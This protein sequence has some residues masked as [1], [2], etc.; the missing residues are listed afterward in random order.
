MAKKTAGSIL[1]AI[2]ELGFR[3]AFWYGIHKAGIYSGLTRKQLPM[4]GFSNGMDNFLCNGWKHI[5]APAQLADVL[6][7]HQDALS[8]QANEIVSGRVRLFGAAPVDLALIPDQPLLHAL[9]YGDRVEKKDIK[10]VWEPARFGWVFPLGR[11][12]TLTKNPLYADAFWSRFE[13]FVEH[14][15]LNAGPNWTSAQEVA[16]RMGG[17]LFAASVF[18]DAP[19]STVQRMNTLA[20]WLY[21]HAARIPP[22]VNYARAQNKDRKSVV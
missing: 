5:P 13:E 1:R 15:P 8:Q 22:T 4:G 18:Q 6:G 7:D 16:L 21:A 12:Y 11:A 2:C 14:N 9:D 10:F 17:W 20:V 19:S 3:Q